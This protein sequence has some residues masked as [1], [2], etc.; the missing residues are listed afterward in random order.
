M[1]HT[2]I[3]TDPAASLLTPIDFLDLFCGGGGSGTGSLEALEL[4]GRR[5]RGTFVNHWD[6]AIQI[7]T[8][9]HPEHRHFCTG[10]DDVSPQE[11]FRREGRVLNF[12]WGSPEC[13]HHSTARGGKPMSEQSRA[14]AQCLIRWIRHERPNWVLVENVPEFRDWGPLMQKRCKKTGKLVWVR[15]LRWQTTRKTWKEKQTETTDVPEDLLHKP[16]FMSRPQWLKRL[17][18]AGYEMALV[19]DKKKKGQLFQQW[20]RRMRKMGYEVQ[21]RVLCAAEYGD[22]TS[23]KRIFVQAVRT[24]IGRCTWPNAT[25]VKRHKETNEFTRGMLPFRTARDII[26]WTDK[27]F[28]IFTRA[29]GLK[30]KTMKRIGVGFEKFIVRPLVKAIEEGKLDSFFQG[31]AVPQQAGGQQ[32]KSADDPVSPVTTRSGEMVVQSEIPGAIV[33]QQG[34]STAQDTN[35]PVTALTAQQHHGVLQA[36]PYIIPQQSFDDRVRPIDQPAPTVTCDSRGI[37]VA[38]AGSPHMAR[39]MIV[40]FKGTGT[41]VQVDQP[42]DTVQSGGLHYAKAIM[43]AFQMAIDQHGS[44]GSCTAPID[45]PVGGTV[46]KNNKA[47][48]EAAAFVHSSDHRPNSG[49]AVHPIDEPLPAVLTKAKESL[50]VADPNFIVETAHGQDHRDE[51]R[52]VK[53]PDNPMGT[54]HASGTNQAVASGETAFVVPQFGERDTQVPRTHPVDEPAPAV[55]SHGAG[56]LVQGESVKFQDGVGV[57]VPFEQSYLIQTAYSGCDDSRVRALLEPLASVAGN[58]GDMALVRPWIYV[59]YS[60]GSVGAAI[61]DPVPTVRTHDSVGVCYPAIEIQGNI[62]VFDI[63]FR[64]LKVRELA[65]AQGFRD[66]YDFPV[67]KTEAVR[68]IGNAVPRNLARALVLACVGQDPDVMSRIK[69]LP[70]IREQIRAH[71]SEADALELFGPMENAA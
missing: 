31:F 66:D 25:H 44:N 50:I 62:L 56:A 46:T 70:E 9:N 64:M 23:R 11:L 27:G 53:D 39:P 1:L 40:K 15:I 14:T 69:N 58:R 33:Q 8:H 38:Q 19:A 21:W 34:Q 12:L 63:F 60:S 42:M 54:V 67:N 71:Y 18:D 55:T 36:D 28:S 24:D 52:R 35:A 32:A 51:A 10:V 20:V 29:K 59:Y 7:H 2:V 5:P 61:D 43:E 4:L 37:G 65:R 6:K 45:Q 13:T 17:S 68:A 48:V 30:E 41:V 49:D 57:L 3:E 16:K 22:P 47:V 26:D